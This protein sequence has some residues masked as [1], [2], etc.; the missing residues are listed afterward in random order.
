M[1][2]AMIHTTQCRYECRCRVIVDSTANGMGCT[3]SRNGRISSDC[4][5][6]V[7][8]IWRSTILLT[9]I[10]PPEST[11]Y[12]NYSAY[13]WCSE[14]TEGDIGY[15]T[16]TVHW[17]C[18][19]RGREAAHQITINRFSTYSGCNLEWNRWDEVQSNLTQDSLVLYQ[20]L[21]SASSTAA[22]TNH[23]LIVNTKEV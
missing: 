7:Q 23:L 19:Y 13:W 21:P 15:W 1:K 2:M 8:L 18:G 17:K 14:S 4:T 22:K 12:Y 16:W 10:Q 6:G 3:G 9:K 5:T 20:F 11:S